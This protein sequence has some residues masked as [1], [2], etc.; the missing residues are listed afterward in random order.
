VIDAAKHLPPLRR[1]RV[2]TC[3]WM[4]GRLT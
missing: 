4:H 2:H 3:Y 1:K